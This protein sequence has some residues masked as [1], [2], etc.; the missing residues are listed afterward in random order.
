[1][2]YPSPVATKKQ[3]LRVVF[4]GSMDA[5]QNQ[6]A[7]DYLLEQIWPLIAR[8]LPQSELFIVGKNPPAR[9]LSIPD[10]R[11]RVTGKVESVIPFL[12]D[13]NVAIVPILDGSGTRFKILEAMACGVP[14]VSTPL[15]C[16][17][18]DVQNGFDI[19][20]EESADLLAQRTIELLKSPQQQI[21]I[22]SKAYKLVEQK[23]SLEANKYKLQSLCSML[24]KVNNENFTSGNA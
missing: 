13:A 21:S 4:T 3:S 2:K 23:Y 17:G 10:P 24:L 15:G 8:E 14:V 19:L 9:W 12:Q 11:V 22:S 1:C 5:F 18:I 16:Q 20:V 7:G 6:R